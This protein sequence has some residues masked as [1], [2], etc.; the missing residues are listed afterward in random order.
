M[1]QNYLK[2]QTK[3]NNLIKEINDYPSIIIIIVIMDIR[4]NGGGSDVYWSENIVNPLLNKQVTYEF[5][6]LNSTNFQG[7]IYLL[8]DDHVI[9]RLKALQLL[10]KVQNGLP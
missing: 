7:K 6:P 4:G 9:L 5:N 1:Q 2:D 8:V 3:I 10:L